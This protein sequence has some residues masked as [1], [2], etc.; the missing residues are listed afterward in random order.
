MSDE[1]CTDE[2]VER[3]QR[4]FGAGLLQAMGVAASL[5][6]TTWQQTID[7]LVGDMLKAAVESEALIPASRLEHEAWWCD[8]CISTV[9][10]N[11]PGTNHDTHK[12][13]CILPAP[14][15]PEAL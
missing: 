4:I 9:L 3:C 15:E 6:P 12:L 10:S 14:D 13:Y 5:E 1:W 11:H 7:Y 2:L 8:M